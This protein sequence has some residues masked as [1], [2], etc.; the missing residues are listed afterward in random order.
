MFATGTKTVWANSCHSI[1]LVAWSSSGPLL[2]LERMRFRSRK[3]LQTQDTITLARHAGFY[4][5]GSLEGKANFRRGIRVA[6]DGSATEHVRLQVPDA[7]L[8]EEIVLSH[9][10]RS[11]VR[12]VIREQVG[13]TVISRDAPWDFAIALS[14][15]TAFNVEITS[16]AEDHDI[17]AKKSGEELM[18][19]H[20]LT[21]EIPLSLLKRLS[22]KFPNE[23][24]LELI[25]DAESRL[26]RSSTLVSNPFATNGP[27]LF[28]E[29]DPGP[30]KRLVDLMKDAVEAKSQKRH[31]GKCNTIL[32]LDN[33]TTHYD[34]DNFWEAFEA[35]HQAKP[36]PVFAEVW[37]YTGY[38][39]EFDGSES[40]WS[41]IPVSVP[42]NVTDRLSSALVE[43]GLQPNAAGIV[44][45]GFRVS[46]SSSS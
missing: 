13:V 9:F 18:R 10:L 15:G 8:R 5:V 2:L 32:I 29:D 21:S 25:A 7:R 43:N 12:W 45:G 30:T 6:P 36:E 22:R 20:A 34:L 44:H 33:R 42:A 26:A 11:R 19:M 31:A 38:Y 1:G 4:P 37:F 28:F 39:S 35:I 16:I 17:F 27:L 46:G 23:R 3:A 14:N 40:E 24:A 41:L